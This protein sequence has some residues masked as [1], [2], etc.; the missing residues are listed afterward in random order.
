MLTRDTC[1]C[2]FLDLHPLSLAVDAFAGIEEGFTIYP[3]PARRNAHKAFQGPPVDHSQFRNASYLPSAGDH[4][5]HGI[6]DLTAYDTHVMV[7]YKGGISIV[8]VF[9]NFARLIIYDDRFPRLKITPTPF[10]GGDI[11]HHRSIPIC[12]PSQGGALLLFDYLSHIHWGI[13]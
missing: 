2:F 1:C 10:V 13:L 4:V 12:S 3:T 8:V 9:C 11:P 6:C 5:A 7:R